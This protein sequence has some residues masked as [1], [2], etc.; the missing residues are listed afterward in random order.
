[1]QVLG[2]VIVFS[3]VVFSMVIH[4]LMHGLASYWL[5]DDTAKL[6]GRLSLNPLKHID[7]VMTLLVPVLLYMAGGPIF[8]GA[9]PVPINTNKIKYGDYGLAL[10]ALAGPLSNLVLA[11]ISFGILTGLGADGGLLA[12]IL[13]LMVQVNLGFMIFNLLPIPPLDG[14]RIIYAIAPEFVQSVMRKIEPYGIVVVFLLI[15]TFSTV[16]A[17][18]MQA[19]QT[20]IIEIFMGIFRV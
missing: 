12:L 2:I 19:A 9:K 20:I 16:F 6:Q 3:V 18:Y 11:F 15:S 8:G 14:S 5:G 17:G 4:E 7:P 13:S 10:V 1:M